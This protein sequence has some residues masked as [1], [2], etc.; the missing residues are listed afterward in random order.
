M[1]GDEAA[2]VATLDAFFERSTDGVAANTCARDQPS[3]EHR[4]ALR[5]SVVESY[6][7]DRREEDRDE[8]KP[9]PLR[10]CKAA[11]GSGSPGGV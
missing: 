9:R 7:L 11:E 10:C 8:E 3:A 4:A 5:R 2:A 6:N 1:P